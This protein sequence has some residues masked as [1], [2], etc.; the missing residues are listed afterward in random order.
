MKQ[1]YFV[2]G[3]DTGVGKTLVSAALIHS[4]RDRGLRVSGMKPVASGCI[5]TINGRRNDDADRL[6]DASNVSAE[7]DLI[8]P[9]R[10]LPPIAPHIAARQAGIVISTDYIVECYQRL[11]S[12]CD[13]VVVEGAGG[14]RVPL[15]DEKSMSDLARELGLPVVIVVG[16]RLGCINHALLTAES[17]LASGLSVAGWVF[18]QIDP[19]MQQTATVKE[20]LQDR[21]PGCLI[22][23]I[24]W[25]EKP[26]AAEVSRDFD[27]SFVIP[28]AT[29]VP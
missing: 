17:I 5:E 15:D 19:D 4:L 3:T 18:N 20:T 25:Q 22:A 6:I 10:F 21:M 1:G 27:S 8:C 29:A 24:P 26:D 2:T 12:S 11:E 7:Y 23:D 14:W 16:A 9:Y 28:D 13:A